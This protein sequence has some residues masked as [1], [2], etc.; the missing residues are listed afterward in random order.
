MRE[1]GDDTPPL[2]IAATLLLRLP[3]SHPPPNQNDRTTTNSTSLNIALQLSDWLDHHQKSA[4]VT[5]KQST[6]T[7]ILNTAPS[8]QFTSTECLSDL[9]YIQDCRQR[10]TIALQHTSKHVAMFG[11]IKELKPLRVLMPSAPLKGKPSETS[12]IDSLMGELQNYAA[13]LEEFMQRG[14]PSN[15]MDGVGYLSLTW[16]CPL[17]QTDDTTSTHYETH[18][19]LAWERVNVLYNLAVLCTYLAAME[20]TPGKTSHTRAQY[21]KAGLQLQRAATLVRYIRQMYFTSSTSAE[22]DKNDDSILHVWDTSLL[23]CNSSFCEV[24]QLHLLAEAQRMAYQTFVATT[25]IILSSA[26]DVANDKAKLPNKPKHFVLA[27]LA[28]AATPLYLAA[29]DLCQEY[30]SAQHVENGMEDKNPNNLDEEDGYHQWTNTQFIQIWDDSVRAHGMWM[31]ALAEYHQSFVH[32]ERQGPNEH[33]LELSR[34]EGAIKFAEYCRDFCESTTSPSLQQLVQQQVI[35]ILHDMEERYEIAKREN[36]QLYHEAIPD[37]DELPEIAQVLSVK[38]DIENISKLLPALNCEPALFGN[39]LDPK[40]RSYVDLFRSK[41]QNVIVQT[42]QLTDQQTE[43]ARSQLAIWHLPHS[44]TAYQQ[45]HNG[46]GIPEDL[47]NRVAYVQEHHILDQLS[48]DMWSIRAR[49]DTCRSLVQQI[50]DVLTKDLQVD[51]AFRQVH[52][53]FEGHDVQEIQKMFRQALHNYKLLLDSAHESDISLLERCELF[54]TDPKFRLLKLPKSQL[55][56]MFPPVAS[57]ENVDVKHNTYDI[58]MLSNCLIDLS[59][60]IND[61]DNIMHRLKEHRKTYNI[62]KDLANM[63]PHTPEDICT[64]LVDLALETLQPLV[65]EISLN[66]EK[67]AKLLSRIETENEQFVKARDFQLKRRLNPPATTASSKLVGGGAIVKIHDSLEE[68]ELFSNHVKEGTGF[69]DIIIPKL[70]K[71]QRQVEEVSSRLAR[72]RMDYETS[73]SRLQHRYDSETISDDRSDRFTRRGEGHPIMD[74]PYSNLQQ[75]S[76]RQTRPSIQSNGSSDRLQY[77]QPRREDMDISRPSGQTDR[78]E[79]RVDDEKLANLVGMD[80]DPSKVVAALMRHNNDFELAL[81]D[82]LSN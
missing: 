22:T 3:V 49:S 28:A 6:T 71:L 16:Q 17:Y 44:I 51:A 52:G 68:I 62:G 55:D 25:P 34:L 38:T 36:D 20:L 11:T 31:T 79:V 42:E 76:R 74:L 14:F 8:P 30:K 77:L 27:K 57:A 33:G 19:S 53:N 41:A 15:D 78:P 35:P 66:L 59:T 32:R 18:H 23:L 81:N 4:D 40:L 58:T 67:Q 64:H 29:E 54:T 65:H 80:F 63:G 50:D 56:R 39:I 43:S 69:Y 82:L 10:V 9:Q 70:N 2:V 24:L 13:L 45:E 61:R 7:P 73:S 60:L 75:S 72:E 48:R 5:M 21:T 26:E 1:N 46:G 37:H 12:A 47:W